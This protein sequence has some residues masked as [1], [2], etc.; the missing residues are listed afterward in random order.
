MKNCLL[1]LAVV[2][3][4]AIG[5]P[6]YSQY[7]F[8]DVNGDGHN[9]GNPTVEPGTV[10]NDILGPATTSV[11]VYFD[12]NHNPDGSA[13]VCDQTASNPLSMNSYA[14]LVRASGSGSV[15]FNGWTDNVGF[16]IGLIPLGDGK[17]F[18]A[19]TDAWI[20]IGSA[21]YLAPNRYKIGTLSVTVTGTPVI[22]FL[23]MGASTI[24][25]TADTDFGTQCEGLDLDQTYKLGS[26]FPLASAYGTQPGVLVNS[27]TWGKIK[28]LYR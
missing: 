18:T 11:A 3:M 8:L 10:G 7:L 21:T 1:F 19:G 4:L 24:K 15:T 12:T 23:P 17:F 14:V 28:Q 5:G 25:P 16:A 27:T 20:G 6:A 13:A 2:A 26:D 22:S 9:S